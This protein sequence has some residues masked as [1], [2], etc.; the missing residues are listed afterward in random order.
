MKTIA[1]C[2]VLA[3]L[4]LA[5]CDQKKDQPRVAS[6]PKQPQLAATPTAV[7]APNPNAPPTNEEIFSAFSAYWRAQAPPN[8]QQLL[9]PIAAQKY[10]DSVTTDTPFGKGYT[11]S[12]A[13]SWRANANFSYRCDDMWGYDIYVEEGVAGPNVAKPGDAISC[14]KGEAFS[15]VEE[16]WVMQMD[17]MHSYVLRR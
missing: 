17:M 8:Y 14:A 9:S 6:A 2:G 12:V 16:G 10:N 11:V 7:A 15:K 1:L 13:F 3:V 5:S 4:L